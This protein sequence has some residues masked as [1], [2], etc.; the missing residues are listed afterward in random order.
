MGFAP[1]VVGRM[2]FWQYV[3]ATSGYVAGNSVKKDKAPSDE[4]FFAAIG[5]NDGD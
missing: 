2:S 3:A 1:D 4:E 5:E